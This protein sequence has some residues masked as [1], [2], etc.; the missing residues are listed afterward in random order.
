[1]ARAALAGFGGMLVVGATLLTLSA[2]IRSI[3]K[4]SAVAA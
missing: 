4:L 3:P 2:S 1:M